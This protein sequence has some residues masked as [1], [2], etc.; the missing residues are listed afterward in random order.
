MGSFVS[1]VAFG[2]IVD[3]YGSYNVPFIPMATL[4]FIGAWL[5]LK[6]DPSQALIPRL[7]AVTTVDVPVDVR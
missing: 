7:Q 3:H 4:L 1:A 5:W 2:Y 6:I